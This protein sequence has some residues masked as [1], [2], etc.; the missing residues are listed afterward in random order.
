M[1]LSAL[2]RCLPLKQG[3]QGAM[4][5]VADI[6]SDCQQCAADSADSLQWGPGHF[7]SAVCLIAGW[8][9]F[10]SPWMLLW[11]SIKRDLIEPLHCWTVDV[12]LQA[13][14]KWFLTAMLLMPLA[15]IWSS[16]M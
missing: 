12:I 2:T 9:P 6:C 11:V 1:F 16:I 14:S 5:C 7:S 4:Q 3:V 15:F 8:D 13:T 10:Y